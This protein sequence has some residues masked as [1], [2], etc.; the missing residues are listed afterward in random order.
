MESSSQHKSSRLIKT[1]IVIACIVSVFLIASAMDFGIKD[2]GEEI[3]YFIKFIRDK[4]TLF[5]EGVFEAF[6]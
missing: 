2:L 1:I 6:R 4:I 3:G 5:L